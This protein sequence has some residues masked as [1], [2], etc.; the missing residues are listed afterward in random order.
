MKERKKERKKKDIF[1]YYI[2]SEL[3]FF[4]K[5]INLKLIFFHKK[6]L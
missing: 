6:V 3:N 1:I 2:N 4:W 5:L